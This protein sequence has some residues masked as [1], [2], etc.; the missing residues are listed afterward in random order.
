MIFLIRGWF[1]LE[2]KMPDEYYDCKIYL[3]KWFE[4]LDR[5]Q[6]HW[7]QKSF[8]NQNQRGWNC[9]SAARII[10][11]HS[12]NHHHHQKINLVFNSAIIVIVITLIS[13]WKSLL[14][15]WIISYCYNLSQ[16]F[17]ICTQSSSASAKILD[18]V[19]AWLWEWVGEPDYCNTCT[20]NILSAVLHQFAPSVYWK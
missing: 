17:H 6:R 14:S 11:D 1:L 15:V 7:W 18:R 12:W 10:L 16:K 9:F 19:P 8:Q 2:L 20:W 13:P 3:S 5:H 4:A